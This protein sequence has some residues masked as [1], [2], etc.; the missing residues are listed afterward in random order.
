MQLN[1]PANIG[2]AFSCHSDQLAPSAR[3]VKDL[4]LLEHQILVVVLCTIEDLTLL[5][6]AM[7]I[8][9]DCLNVEVL[10]CEGKVFALPDRVYLV[11][12]AIDPGLCIMESFNH[13]EFLGD[14]GIELHTEVVYV[15]E[16]EADERLN[17]V[18]FKLAGCFTSLIEAEYMLD[19][20]LL[21]NLSDFHG[22]RKSD[23][24]DVNLQSQSM[25]RMV[26]K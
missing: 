19:F 2:G 12:F 26:L 8:E 21:E 9:K 6:I 7:L 1:L 16:L 11:L 17:I 4:T 5:N 14:V 22:L 18:F 20:L 3:R 23:A 13:G 15:V 24:D 25:R 10:D